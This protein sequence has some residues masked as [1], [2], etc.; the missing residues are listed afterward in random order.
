MD[1]TEEQALPEKDTNRPEEGSLPA[2]SA[3]Q[4]PGEV[5][6]GGTA[7]GTSRLPRI[8]ILVDPG[9]E[10]RFRV[11]VE[12]LD[13]DGEATA[14]RSV[15]VSMGDGG[16]EMQPAQLGPV[17][18]LP[19]APAVP[20]SLWR[21]WGVGWGRLRAALQR[22]AISLGLVLFSLSLALYLV[23]RLIGLESFPIYFFTDEA[24]Q[25]VLAADLVRDNFFGYD[26]VFLPTYFENGRQYNLGLSVYLQLIPFLFFGKSVFVT[27]ATSVLVTLL[28][29]L[30]IGLTLRDIFK[31]P[32]W[33]AGA[34]LISI[35]PAWFLHSRTAFETVLAASLYAAFL[36][37]YLL[38]RHRSPRY[39]Y[40]A[41]VAGALVFYAYSAAQL[42]MALTGVLLLLS[43]WRYHWQHRDKVMRGA[44]LALLLALPYLRFKLIHPES[45]LEHLEILGSYWV[46]ED[47]T[48]PEKVRRYFSEYLYGLSP[49]YWF[50]PNDK[51]LIRHV[52]KGYGHILR[53][54]LPLMLLGLG[55]G[56]KNI[57]KPAYRVLFSALLAAPS[58]AAIVG[59]GVTR[60]LVFLIPATLFIALGLSQ[61]LAWLE[62]LRLP[63]PALALGVFTLLAVGNV[64]MT[65]D[66]LVNGPTWYDEYGLYGMQYGARQV[67]G[68]IREFA[69]A[70]PERKILLSPTWANGTEI[71]ARFFLPD[72]MP[73]EMGNAEP[74]ML[75]GYPIE[76]RT[77]F[78]LPEYE[79]RQVVESGKFA[80]VKVEKTLHYPDGR[81][82]FYFVHLRYVDNIDEI[83]AAE[84]AERARLRQAEVTI[85]G[86]TVQVRHSLLDMGEIE[87]LFDGKPK[88]LARTMEANPFVLELTFPEPQ[89]V[90]GYDII[91]G[92]ARGEI[93]TLVYPSQEG[94]PVE[95]RQ[96]FEG[97]I[98]EPEVSVDF[99]G[100]INARVVRIE[101][102]DETQEEIGHVHI[103][104]IRLR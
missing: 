70:D 15:V 58:G 38:Y 51:D 71:V 77:L 90:S 78:V 101:V 61:A 67:F 23:P 80:E 16:V 75:H 102:H 96:S 12:A 89:E 79:Y 53:A 95:F 92:S 74:Y 6:P 4:S 25:T 88:T 39:L 19:G 22:R 65:R 97:S 46:S 62:R 7:G 21:V 3:D 69:E 28:A 32:Y 76:P 14:S 72:S 83:L 30:A 66:A 34:L 40:P 81:P 20:R 44:G 11:T 26:K 94:E 33:W 45:T 91:I 36:Y 55:V 24:I 87:A 42:Y 56:L 5:V 29:P 63:R 31:I 57:R 73:V 1:E 41:V 85:D 35:T 43:D 8:Q 37:L 82:G 18:P 100:A 60:L 17:A 10:Q 49:A 48:F 52:M 104:E 9:G 59:I 64:A 50:L 47:F 98:E 13:G 99:G 84:R 86:Q 27:R 103:W 2:A 68:A 93:V 54:A